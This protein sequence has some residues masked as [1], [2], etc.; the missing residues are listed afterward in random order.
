MLLKGF[1]KH[2]TNI[3]KSVSNYFTVFN[4]R[5]CEIILVIDKQLLT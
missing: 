1:L 2:W 3:L 5:K 4:I